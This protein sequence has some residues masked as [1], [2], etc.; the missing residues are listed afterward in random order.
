MPDFGMIA[1][2]ASPAECD[3][4]KLPPDHG[5]FRITGVIPGRPG[6]AAGFKVGDAMVAINGTPFRR[7]I[8]L[9]E[10]L[11]MFQS[12]LEGKKGSPLK[13]TIL[14]KGE[15]KELILPVTSK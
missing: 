1:D 13:V 8:P 5:G 11:S 7:S 12:I 4:I 6:E 15:R 10:V 9:K 2:Q 3:A 14:R